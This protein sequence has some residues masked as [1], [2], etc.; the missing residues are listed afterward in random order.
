[1]EIASKFGGIYAKD[2]FIYRTVHASR[3][4][5][6]H[7]LEHYTGTQSAPAAC[8]KH[9]RRKGSS[10]LRN[11]NLTTTHSKKLGTLQSAGQSAFTPPERGGQHE[12]PYEEMAHTQGRRA[13]SCCSALQDPKHTTGLRNQRTAGWVGA[14]YLC[15]QA[16]ESCFGPESVTNKAIQHLHTVGRSCITATA[17]T[18]GDSLGLCPNSTTSLPMPMAYLVSSL[19]DVQLGSGSIT[20][21]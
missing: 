7:I 12:D 10:C 3:W 19:P 6:T 13:G 20:I 2:R 9:F 18:N 11:V 16:V 21:L 1:M 14:F 8:A 4:I 5:F 17:L 15:M